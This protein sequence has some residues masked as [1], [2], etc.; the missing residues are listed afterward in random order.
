MHILRH[1]TLGRLPNAW[2]IT[3]AAIFIGKSV[4]A[5]PLN[6]RKLG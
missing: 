2:K 3:P 6:S 1:N 4:T 5:D